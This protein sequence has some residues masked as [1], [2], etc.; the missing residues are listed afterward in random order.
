MCRQNDATLVRAARRFL[1]RYLPVCEVNK[2]VIAWDVVNLL[3][4]TLNIH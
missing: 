3:L 1:A 2:G 4:C